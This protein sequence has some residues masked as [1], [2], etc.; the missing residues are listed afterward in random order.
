MAI[1]ELITT[2]TV[3]G[4]VDFGPFAIEYIDITDIKVSL[5]GVLQT[6]TTEYTIDS[7]TSTVTFVTAPTTGQVI[8]IFRETPIETAKAVL[9]PGS[10]IRAQNLNDNTEQ[11]LFAIQE[12]KSQFVTESGGE[13]VTDVDFNDNRLTNVAD[14]TD[15]QDAVTKQY[16]EDNYFDDGTETI[17]SSEAWAG[18]DVTIATTSA[19]D[20]RVDAKIDSAITGD[21]GTD[22]T[23]IT[24]TNDGDGTI[25]LGLG[26]GSIDFDRIKDVD[27][28]TSAETWNS[29]D[30]QV[31]TTQ[32]IDDY[33]DTAITNDIGVD[34]TGLTVTDDGDGT[35]TLGIGANS[36]DLDRIKDGDIISLAEQD[37][38]SPAPADTNIFTASA[39]AKRFDT[40]VQTG[41]PSGSDYEVGKTWLQNDNNRT[42]SIWN[43]SA[44]LTVSQG[45]GFVSQPS[46]VYVDTA[47]GDDAADGHRISTPKATIKGAINQINAEIGTEITSGGS[48]YVTGSYSAVPLTGGNGTGLTADITVAA[49]VV[50]AV[51]VNSTATLENYSIGDVLSANNADLGGSGSG[52]QVTV[53]GDGDGQIVVV[54][55][56]VYQEVA[57]IQIKRRNVSI[58]GQALRS[59]IVHPT[60]ATETNTLFE[61]NSGSY[62]SNLTLTGMKAGTTGTNA[63][64]AVLPADQG[65]N[66]AFYNDAFI[67]KSPYIQNCTNFSD[68]EIDNN[69]LR[70]HNPRGGIAGDTDSLPT[71]GGLLVNGATPHDN[72]PLRSMVCDSYTHVGLNGPGILVTNNGYAQ[73]TSSY[74]FFNRYHIKTLNGGQANLAA[75]TT[76]FGN[77]ALV[78]DGR[79]TT[80]IFS[81]SLSTNI[82]SGDTTF[83]IGAPTADASWHGTATRPQ[84]NMLVDVNGTFY[85]ILSAVANGAGWDVTISRPD[86]TDRSNN[87]GIN[88]DVT[89]PIDID[90]YLRSQI[91]SSGHTMEYVGSGTNYS[92]LP[93]NGGVPVEANQVVESNNGKIWTATTDHNGKF[94]VGDFFEVDQELGFVTIPEGS[95]A[96]DLLSDQSPQLGAN[97]D[98][99]GNTITGL[100]STPTANDE[101]VSKQYVDT[102]IG[103]IDEVVEDLTPQLGGDLDVNG[104]T[105]TSASN[106]NIVIDPNGTGI[107]SLGSNVGVGTASPARGPLH[108]HTSGDTQLHMTNSTTGATDGDGFTI[109]VSG[110]EALLVQR[111]VAPLSFY[112]AQ[113]ERLRIDSSGRVGIGTSS[114]GTDGYSSYDNL[115]IANS[116]HCG[117]TIKS[118]NNK[119]CG[120]NFSDTAGS[121]VGYIAYEHSSDKLYFGNAGSGH[122]AFDSS[123]RLGIGETS[124]GESLD[125]NGRIRSATASDSRFLL[126]VN[127]VNKGGFSATTDDGVVI[128]GASS[129]NPIRFQTSGA[130]KARIDS[131]G[132]LLVG[133]TSAPISASNRLVQIATSSGGFFVA[134]NSTNDNGTN[135]YLGGLHFTG[136]GNN[137]AAVSA[138]IEGRTDGQW[139]A[140]DYPS[141][142]EFSTTADGAGG[143]TERVR[144]QSDG[145]TK[146]FGGVYGNEN[147]ITAGTGGMDLND[148]NF[149]TCA[150]ITIP[151]P[152]N[153]VAGMSGLIRVTAAPTF[154]TGWDFPGG[155]YT[156]PTAFPAI[157]PFYIVN[158]S[159][160][161]LGNWTEGIA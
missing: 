5:D 45:G 85:S 123:G 110:S 101:A 8:R 144:I 155:T 67:T 2:Q 12:I 146:F 93:E 124:P 145:K 159:T 44:W 103:G 27:I 161:L 71:G 129:T 20:N 111:E 133:A 7:A 32:A 13:F 140:S 46:V 87:L 40:L 47:S 114:P 24:I 131:S 75:S 19:I 156:A 59:C 36:V 72:S 86:P 97:L 53:N 76:D 107:I 119:F 137:N 79:S 126:R 77:Q 10:S 21:I 84:S 81:A 80:A 64:D 48:G 143:P 127:S 138:R 120:I 65:W 139:G 54:A 142:L 26:A 108:L 158:S 51:T 52:L 42:L 160:F 22:G 104:Q 17:L 90:F 106:G 125:V 6:L 91:A 60:P 92:A 94:K 115:V 128:Y 109:A 30:T 88:G 113:S 116:D 134:H 14:P 73:C 100:P 112:T 152:T 154:A 149:W 136:V 33:V 1:T 78:A 89:A 58:I 151:L 41:I 3:G 121:I 148:G 66:F 132:R 18:D 63:D 57:P 153:G 147:T 99:N 95:I 83:T 70:A 4:N 68:S 56:G 130:E 141:R 35:I 150:G 135:A 29:S 34:A 157:A 37:A 102:Q 62:I 49:G 82:T 28:I 122:S 39:A 98:V 16:L 23:G 31:A 9:S 117:I 69:D 15:P 50:T 61:L 118:P 11:A 38:G 25:T 74:A 55:A 96:F 43:G 105:I